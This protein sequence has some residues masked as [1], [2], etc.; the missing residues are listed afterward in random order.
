[1]PASLRLFTLMATPFM[2]RWKFHK[3][4]RER[5]GCVLER[6]QLHC[7]QAAFEGRIF[8]SWGECDPNCDQDISLSTA[9]PIAPCPLPEETPAPA[10]PSIWY[11]SNLLPMIRFQRS[12]FN[13]HYTHRLNSQVFCD[14]LQGMKKAL[15]VVTGRRFFEIDMN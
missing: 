5:K 2:N 13:N 4:R 8:P 3:G 9:Q 10:C 14:V 11:R 12:I 7:V 15:F 6:E 1:M